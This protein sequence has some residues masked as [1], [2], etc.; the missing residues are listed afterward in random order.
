MLSAPDGADPPRTTHRTVTLLAV[1]AFLS[2][3]ALRICDGLLR[4]ALDCWHTA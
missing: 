4:G 1:A 2:G 3:A